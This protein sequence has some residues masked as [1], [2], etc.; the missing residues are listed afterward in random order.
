LLQ[1]GCFVISIRY[2]AI[3]RPSMKA[4]NNITQPTNQPTLMS[5]EAEESSTVL[6][7]G[8][9]SSFISDSPVLSLLERILVDRDELQRVFYFEVGCHLAIAQLKA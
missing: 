1:I 7:A 2:H 8:G 4:Q 3:L 5:V 9:G 6:P